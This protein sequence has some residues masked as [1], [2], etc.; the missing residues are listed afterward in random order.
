MSDYSE[1]CE[2]C[3]TRHHWTTTP[4]ASHVALVQ[5]IVGGYSAELVGGSCETCDQ[6]VSDTRRHYAEG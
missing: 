2:D 6:M 3:G 1:T 5:Y 4:L